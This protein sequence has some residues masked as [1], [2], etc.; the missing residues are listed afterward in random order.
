[1]KEEKDAGRQ[2]IVVFEEGMEAEQLIGPASACCWSI[3]MP[4]AD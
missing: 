1:M 4:F 2:E 3:L